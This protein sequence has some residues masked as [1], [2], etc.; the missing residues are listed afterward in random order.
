MIRNWPRTLIAGLLVIWG[1]VFFLLFVLP[2]NWPP[3]FI[4]GILIMATVVTAA[5]LWMRTLAIHH[6]YK[7]PLKVRRHP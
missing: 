6:R 5:I 3:W 1:L 2:V 7:K 4:I